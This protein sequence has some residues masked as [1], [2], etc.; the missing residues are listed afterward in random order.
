VLKLCQERNL[1]LVFP[2][3]PAHGGVAVD[4]SAGRPIVSRALNL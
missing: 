4:M 1:T 2:H 3:D